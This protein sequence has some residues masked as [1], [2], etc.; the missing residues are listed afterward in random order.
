MEACSKFESVFI[1][2]ANLIFNIP[3]IV[4]RKCRTLW[5]TLGWCRLSPWETVIIAVPYRGD[6][7]VV[8][9]KAEAHGAYTYASIMPPTIF[10]TLVYQTRRG[11]SLGEIY[12][13]ATA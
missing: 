13:I 3:V 6:A 4:H 1:E 12:T 8:R 5:S 11:S 10:W 2:S 9:D 7:G